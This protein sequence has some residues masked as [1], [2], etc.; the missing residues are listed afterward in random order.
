MAYATYESGLTTAGTWDVAPSNIVMVNDAT[1]RPCDRLQSVFNNSNA[2]VGLT[3]TTVLTNI[4][5][6]VSLAMRSAANLIEF[7]VSG[8]T[9]LRTGASSGQGTVFMY[10]DAVQLTSSGQ[11]NVYRADGAAGDVIIPWSIL[12]FDKPNSTAGNTYQ[13]KAQNVPA[14]GLISYSATGLRVHEIMG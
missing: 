2:S 7:S 11:G 4:G 10:R 5:L 13:P 8:Y 3:S 6:N 9:Y 12:G 1:P 14:A